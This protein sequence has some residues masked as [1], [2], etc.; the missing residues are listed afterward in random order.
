MS[1]EI[2]ERHK[3]LEDK[4]LST[5]FFSCNKDLFSPVTQ[6]AEKW[7]GGIFLKR[8]DIM[9]QICI[10]QHPKHNVQAFLIQSVE[11]EIKIMLRC[12]VDIQLHF[13]KT[14]LFFPNFKF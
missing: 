3:K 13:F 1:K 4:N 9:S 10:I 12:H 7:T 14:I 11:Q 8:D 5:F 2:K 6:N